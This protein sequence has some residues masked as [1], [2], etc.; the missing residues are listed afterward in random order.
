MKVTEHIFGKLKA[1]FPEN[2][3]PE[4]MVSEPPHEMECEMMD[5]MEDS[6]KENNVLQLELPT[7]KEIARFAK[8]ASKATAPEPS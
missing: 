4:M 1:L 3:E 8:R 5:M 6:T 7:L 2:P